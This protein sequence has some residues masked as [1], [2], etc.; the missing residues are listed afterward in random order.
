MFSWGKNKKIKSEALGKIEAMKENIKKIFAKEIKKVLPDEKKG[1][2]RDIDEIGDNYENDTWKIVNETNKA[3]AKKYEE[4]VD[5]MFSKVTLINWNEVKYNDD[6]TIKMDQA[7]KELYLLNRKEIYEGDELQR[8]NSF[9]EFVPER[10]FYTLKTQA[11][12]E[13]DGFTEDSVIEEKIFCKNCNL[14]AGFEKILDPLGEF[15]NPSVVASKGGKKTRKRRKSKKAR[16]SHNK[17]KSYRM[18]H[19]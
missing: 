18:G 19:I 4:L 8:K 16:K 15:L 6:D 7:I 14:Y 13:F 12:E 5:K 11:Q 2:N 3:S 17:R 1:I 10:F 9:A